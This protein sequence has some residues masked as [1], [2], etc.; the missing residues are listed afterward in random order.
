MIEV[1]MSI[2]HRIN[3]CVDNSIAADVQSMDVRADETAEIGSRV[4]HA[5]WQA[6]AEL[7]NLA[8]RSGWPPDSTPLSVTL[9]WSDWQ[10][11][12]RQLERWVAYEEDLASSIEFLRVALGDAQS[13]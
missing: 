9:L 7:S 2:W 10:W 11:A 4:M 5:G 12:L 6:A 1:P 8:D 3:G 13:S